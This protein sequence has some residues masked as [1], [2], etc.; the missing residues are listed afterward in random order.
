MAEV[1]SIIG[2]TSLLGYFFTRSEKTPRDSLSKDGKELKIIK[3]NGSNI[4]ESNKVNEINEE[5]LNKSKQRYKMAENPAK[6]G[7]L[8]PLFNTYSVVGTTNLPDSKGDTG[9]II[10]SYNDVRLNSYSTKSTKSIENQPMFKELVE[11]NDIEVVGEK[12]HN[13]MVPFFGSR[14]KQNMEEFKNESL[15]DI[16]TGNRSTFKHKKET[17]AFFE[18]QPEDIY[19]TPIFTQNVNIDRFVPSIYKQGEKVVEE[20]RVSA[21]KEGAFDNPIRP[22]YKDV[23]ELRPGNKPKETFRGEIKVGQRAS[24]RGVAGEFNRKG[25]D[26]FYEQTQDQL[27]RTTADYLEAKIPENF[28]TNFKPTHRQT[29]T[30]EFYGL[31]QGDTKQRIYLSKDCQ[32]QGLNTQF[33][34]STRTNDENNYISHPEV[35]VKKQNSYNFNVYN[36]ERENENDF[37]TNRNLQTGIKLH[38]SQDAKTTVKETT[39][40]TNTFLGGNVNPDIKKGDQTGLTDYTLKNTHKSST[41][42]NKYVGNANKKES[43]GLGYLVNKQQVKPTFKEEIIKGARP[44]GHQKF[45]IANGSIGEIKLTN[46]MLL[47]EE[48]DKRD[49]MNIFTQQIISDKSSI[50][51][52]SKIKN[53][54]TKERL[55]P[56]ILN[57]LNDNPFIGGRR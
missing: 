10:E 54:R 8:P 13:N 16:Q 9:D 40:S 52:T 30:T 36:T 39:L 31:A 25:P 50:G 3:P 51:T 11:P 29:S 21:P 24:V 7:I 45:Q 27:L 35:I 41:I 15:L 6:S 57:Q 1:V 48:Q 47:K 2:L 22:V 12:T 44:G 38:L 43:S 34:E 46:N 49:L 4:Y 14:I 17:N 19:G 20:I 37:L 32:Q 26:T 18:Q 42:K 23:N 55:D 5:L 56:T 33:K 28:E 53:N